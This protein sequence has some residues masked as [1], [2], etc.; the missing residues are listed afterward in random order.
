MMSILEAK[1]DVNSTCFLFP[2][3]CKVF[4]F[5]FFAMEYNSQNRTEIKENG[6]EAQRN[7]SFYFIF[8]S[9]FFIPLNNIK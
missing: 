9:F 6:K 8:F 3:Y 1:V 5:F 7:Y 2:L 4:F